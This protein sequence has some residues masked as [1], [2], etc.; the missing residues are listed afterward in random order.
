[1]SG[2]PRDAR[3][4][5]GF[6]FAA[7]GLW[8][9]GPIVWK[10][11]DQVPV[12][13]LMAQRVVWSIPLL[14][15]L[16]ALFHAWGELRVGLRSGHTLR[17][18]GLTAGLLTINW[19]LFVYGVASG[20]ILAVSLG[21]FLNPLVNVALAMLFLRERLRPAQG[22]AVGIAAA[23][24]AYMAL[25]LDAMP[26]IS[27]ALAFSF[28]FYGLLRKT[29]AV[30]ALV[31]LTVEASVLLPLA[32]GFLLWLWAR[33]ASVSMAAPAA[34]WVW[35][36]GAGVVT[37]FPLYWF[38]Q[39]AKRLRYATLGLLQYLAPSVQFALAV[40]VYGEAFTPTHMITFG[41]IWLALA[42]YTTDSLRAWRRDEAQ[43]LHAAAGDP[44]KAREEA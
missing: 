40:A 35:F 24:V 18:L 8:G 2:D 6:G 30:G 33:G 1:M 23:G 43:R 3:I 34:D 20:Q 14:L 21:Y 12:L 27:L 29:M 38:T 5:L 13:E 31:G 7:Y 44:P 11:V 26:W 37:V 4:G 42:I 15:G 19:G 36:F 41:A 9:L 10:A 32:A 39:A 17:L 28:A 22:V 25:S 16:L